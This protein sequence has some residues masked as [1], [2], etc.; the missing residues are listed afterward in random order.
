MES[1]MAKDGPIFPDSDPIIQS[2]SDRI[3]MTAFGISGHS[4]MLIFNAVTGSFRRDRSLNRLE[5]RGRDRQRTGIRDK[6]PAIRHEVVRRYS[7][8][9]HSPLLGL[10]VYVLP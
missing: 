1:L 7:P 5:K 2:M 8:V 3:S 9:Q 6:R 4:T 10:L